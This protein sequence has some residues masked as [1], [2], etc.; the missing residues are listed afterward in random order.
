MRVSG[1]CSGASIMNI[2]PSRKYTS[3]VEQE[4]FAHLA[5]M[6][7][8]LC[9]HLPAQFDKI[10]QSDVDAVSRAQGFARNFLS[11]QEAEILV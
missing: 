3:G 2:L 4:G 5:S 11:V 7:Y 10:H 8:L 6:L 9:R 1:D